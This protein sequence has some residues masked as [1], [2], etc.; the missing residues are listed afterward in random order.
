MSFSWDEIDEKEKARSSVFGPDF[1]NQF[2]PLMILCRNVPI[3]RQLKRAAVSNTLRC[4]LEVARETIG[5]VKSQKK[6][7]SDETFAANQGQKGS[8]RKDKNRSINNWKEK[9]RKGK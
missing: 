7:I 9:E 2:S 6:W 5:C 3:P 4:C 1:V 8:K